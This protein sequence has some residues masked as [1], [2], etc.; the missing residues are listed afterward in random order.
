[1][2]NGEFTNDKLHKYPHMFPLDIAIWERFLD[3]F[4]A[5]YLGFDYDIKV[6]S[7]T[8][9]VPGL[10][11]EYQRMQAILSKYRVDVVGY[12]N[13]AIYII[14]TK[15]EA[16]TTAIGQIDLYVSLYKRDFNPDR[17]VKGMI[18]TD[19]ELPDVRWHCQEKGI[20][21]VVV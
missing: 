13:N 4:G 19:R 15:P 21:I 6:G 9:P 3:Q 12:T 17:Q 5:D 2:H 14:E 10:T 8:E 20:E 7:G 18:I 11:E 1:M 16:G